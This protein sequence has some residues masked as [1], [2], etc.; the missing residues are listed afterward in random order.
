MEYCDIIDLL[1]K[2][3]Y[4]DFASTTGNIILESNSIDKLLDIAVCENIDN[5]ID[6]NIFSSQQRAKICFRSAYVLEYFFLN[7]FLDETLHFDKILSFYP[8]IK[9]ASSCR[10]FSKMSAVI[11]SHNYDIDAKL[12]ENIG[13]AAAE[14]IFAPKTKVAT[15]IWC[16]EILMNLR[17][18]VEWIDEI[19]PDI[20]AKISVNPTPGLKVA[21]R[22][23]TKNNCYYDK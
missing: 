19:I 18:K 2:D 15:I 23:W 8:H 6:G 12:T 22:K 7:G 10:H 14:W 21:L 3:F 17:N 9:N 4:E 13:E 20:I 11:L 5:I 16:M 1:L